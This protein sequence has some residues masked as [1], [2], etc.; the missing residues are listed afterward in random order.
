MSKKKKITKK[1]RVAPRVS[2]SEVVLYVP[3]AHFPYH[4]QGAFR[5]MIK[6][7]KALGVT[8]IVVLGDFVDCAFASTHAVHES[9]FASLEEEI[10]AA[11]LGIDELESVGARRM[12]YLEGNH[13]ERLPRLIRQNHPQMRSRADN[14]SI[15]HILELG[16]KWDF[17]PYRSHIKLFDRVYVTHDF[18]S[19]GAGALLQGGKV[20][21]SNLIFGHTHR[22]GVAYDGDVEHGTRFT[23]NAGHLVDV[24]YVKYLPAIKTTQWQLGF[25][26]GFMADGFCFLQAVPIIESE[27]KVSTFVNGVYYEEKC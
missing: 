23:A 12:I 4:H 5:L 7:A 22:L 15:R 24:Q 11:R 2:G 9:N 27:D 19:A 6:V 8:M 17:V 20:F 3:D 18:G 10:A 14:F 13:E 26:V 1:V 16:K 25:C 21:G